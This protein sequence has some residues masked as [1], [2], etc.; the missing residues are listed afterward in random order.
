MDLQVLTS[1]IWMDGYVLFLDGK[2][3]PISDM[4]QIRQKKLAEGFTQEKSICASRYEIKYG[5][6]VQDESSHRLWLKKICEESIHIFY[7]L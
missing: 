4:S 2:N 1:D 3:Y 7:I 6:V 5:E